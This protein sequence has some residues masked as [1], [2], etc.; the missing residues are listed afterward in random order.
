MQAHVGPPPTGRSEW[1]PA[2]G[3]KLIT[4]L[5]Q[6]TFRPSYWPPA[7]G[8]VGQSARIHADVRPP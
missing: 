6:P 1:D 5:D 3:I 8:P 2:P 7:R 4:W